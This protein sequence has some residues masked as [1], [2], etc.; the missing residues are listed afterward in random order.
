MPTVEV[1]PEVLAWARQQVAM[2]LAEAAHKVG[3]PEDRLA[4]W[5]KVGELPAGKLTGLAQAYKRPLAMFFMSE[6]PE[7]TS[8]PE[9]YRLRT[10]DG[11][12]PEMRPELVVAIREA[13]EWQSVVTRLWARMPELSVPVEVPL[14]DLEEDRKAAGIR[15][16]EHLG[17]SNSRQL[18]WDDAREALLEWRRE[19]EDRG[20]LVFAIKLSRDVCRG[21]SLWMPAGPPVIGLARESDQARIFTLLHEFVH[22]TLRGS[23]MCSQFEDQSERGRIERFCNQVAANALM[24]AQ[25]VERAI[26]EVFGPAAPVWNEEALRDLAGILCV[27]IPAV[28][29]RVEELGMAPDGTY[30]QWL[31]RAPPTIPK[32]EGGGGG[33]KGSWPGVRISER[34]L[35]YSAVVFSAWQNGLINK[36]DAARVMNM[37]P[38]YV[39]KIGEA[40]R[41]RRGSVG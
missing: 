12:S 19:V 11:R 35:N 40:V 7:G 23:G 16:R 17:V 24:P 26:D 39:P 9:D 32:K 2:S 27:S 21:F 10:I 28:A 33:G 14:L 31:Y 8:L 18:G 34:G 30:E 25:L 4:R 5:E 20:V 41:R 29:L 3:V 15:L 38:E 36:G 22:L 13:R 1:S 37:R 6:P